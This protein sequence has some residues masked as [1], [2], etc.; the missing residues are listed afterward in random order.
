MW[1]IKATVPIEHANIAINELTGICGTESEFGWDV[2][3]LS[4]TELS[5]YKDFDP[6]AWEDSFD[7]ED[8]AREECWKCA[9][10]AINK[11]SDIERFG[12]VT[13]VQIVH[14]H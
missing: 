6:E 7:D 3:I 9:M 8:E 5:F 12:W 4:P 14:T 1:T 2:E 11:A 10:Q 13:S